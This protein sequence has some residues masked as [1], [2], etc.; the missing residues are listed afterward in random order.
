M[1]MS[2]LLDGGDLDEGNDVIE[3][4]FIVEADEGA[5][6]LGIG[7]VQLRPKYP[8]LVV[9]FLASWLHYPPDPDL[10]VA[11]LAPLPTI[12][13]SNLCR[14]KKTTIIRHEGDDVLAVKALWYKPVCPETQELVVCYHDTIDDDNT[15]DANSVEKNNLES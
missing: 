1:D 5:R 15:I 6:A 12:S 7:K 9:A 11:S 10:A 8:D 3:D 2:S 13:R 14:L 4:P